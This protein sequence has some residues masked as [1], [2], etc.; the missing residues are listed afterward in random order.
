MHLQGGGGGGSSSKGIQACHLSKHGML[1]TWQNFPEL[2]DFFKT[3]QG[4]LS[5]AWKSWA[6]YETFIGLHC[7]NDLMVFAEASWNQAKVLN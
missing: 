3:W 2:T 1:G 7:A 5:Y 6:D 4:S